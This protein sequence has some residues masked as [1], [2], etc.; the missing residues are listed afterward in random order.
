MNTLQSLCVAVAL[1]FTPYFSSSCHLVSMTETH[2]VDNGDGTYT[3]TFNIC[4]GIENTYGF[5]LSFTGANLVGYPGS[6]TGPTTGNTINASV[7][8]ISGSGDIE[9]GDWDNNGTPLFSGVGNECVSMSFTFD[10]SISQTEI[11]GTQ[12][13]Y[14][15]GP[16][17]G[18]LTNT[19]CFPATSTYTITINPTNNNNQ[20]YGFYL[21]GTLMATGPTNGQTDVWYYCGPC[22]STFSLSASGPAN[23]SW[24]VVQT[25][26]G[27]TDSGASTVTNASLTPCVPLPVELASFEGESQG[28]VNKLTWVTESERDNDYFMVE[29]SYDGNDW[30][31]IGTV[32]GAGNSNE[33]MHYAHYDHSFDESKFAY[34]RLSQLDNDGKKEVFKMISVKNGCIEET[35]AYS[36]PNPVINELSINALVAAEVSISDAA[37]VVLHRAS[38]GKG[39][40]VINV[41]DYTAGAYFITINS[42]EGE[43]VQK[44]IKK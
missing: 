26:N 43:M 9:Y 15:G 31:T 37:G 24:S 40:H 32:N 27:T 13:D 8:P 16:C 30:E 36:Y 29:R 28:C 34:Y 5:W 6:V 44:F 14:S 10:G 25:A 1:L 4:V 22:A 38:L 42:G 3:Y 12:P 7:P 41:S 20:S 18:I 11:G 39:T 17:G 33:R 2:A 35:L 21:D 23:G 19:T